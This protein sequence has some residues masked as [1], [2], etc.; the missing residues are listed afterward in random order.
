MH[1]YPKAHLIPGEVMS[2]LGFLFCKDTGKR[3]KEFPAVEDQ[4]LLD[5]LYWL[6]SSVVRANTNLYCISQK[7]KRSFLV[8]T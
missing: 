5:C 1:M 8:Q 2:I 3:K 7:K 6:L 4:L